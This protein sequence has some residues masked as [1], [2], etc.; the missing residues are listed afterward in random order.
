MA[1]FEKKKKYF[2]AIDKGQKKWFP[3]VS[4][5]IKVSQVMNKSFLHKSFKTFIAIAIAFSGVL[6]IATLQQTKVEAAQVRS[7]IDLTLQAATSP[8]TI[9]AQPEVNA[10]TADEFYIS[11]LASASEFAIG[12]T[13]TITVPTA[14]TGLAL[15]SASTTNSDG[16]GGADGALVLSGNTFTY[17][18]TAVTTTAVATGVEFCFAGTTPAANGN[19]SVSISDTNDSDTSAA[20]IYVGTT[21]AADTNDVTV[22]ATVPVVL[23][24]S[25]RNP[26]TTANTNSCA[27]GVLNPASIN[28][29]SYRI[30][31]G[32]NGSAGMSVGAVSDGV[33]DSGA[34]TI[35]DVA[36]G[37]VTAGSEEHGVTLTAGTGW[38]LTTPFN[39]GDDPITTTQ[40]EIQDRASV[41]DDSN[42]ANWTTV[43]HR[44][45]IT[46][47]TATGAYDE[48]ITYRA[49]YTP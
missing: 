9:A 22:T 42:T 47:A 27:L 26:S 48:V 10:S 17:T 24:L 19:Y 44:A 40:Q 5:Y 13:V 23:S 20:L 2:A 18:Y 3:I 38:T 29:C 49:Y 25:I 21:A 14:F 1:L 35:N 12:N 45:S 28:T 43:T 15:C 37:A 30:A 31:A 41:V 6:S 39:A 33:L 32:T 46:S 8:A 11:Y 16:S 4:N 36:D 7:Y 34:N